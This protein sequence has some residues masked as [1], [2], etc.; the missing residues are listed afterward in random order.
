MRA[1]R[2]RHRAVVDLDALTIE[3]RRR[4]Q[5]VAACVYECPSCQE[6]YLGERR[7]PECNLFNRN[8]GLGG[9]CAGCDQPLVLIELV[10]GL[11]RTP[12]TSGQAECPDVTMAVRAIGAAGPAPARGPPRGVLGF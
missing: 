5:L 4:S 1:H 8:L 10:P 3:L 9:A 7:C 6:R 2:L 11:L 12:T